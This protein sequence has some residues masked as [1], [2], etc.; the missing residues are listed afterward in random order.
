MRKNIGILVVVVM[1][2][3]M[4]T[5]LSKSDDSGIEFSHA[6]LAEAK[7]LAKESGKIIFIDCYT[8]WCGPCKRMAKTAFKDK[9]VG[10]LFNKSFIN[11]KI[12]MEKNPDGKE[13]SRMYKIRAYPT[14]LM[15]NAE[16]VLVKKS[17]GSQS[18]GD[19]LQLANN[20]LKK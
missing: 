13:I 8:D 16:G 19:L 12:E 6:T 20:V 5:S 18:S 15:I 7:V 11:L 9:E 3:F 1:S 17:V 10:E 4:M 14:L 2:V